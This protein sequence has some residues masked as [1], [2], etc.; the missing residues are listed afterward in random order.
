M[1]QY[2]TVKHLLSVNSHTYINTYIHTYIHTPKFIHTQTNT[3]MYIHTSNIFEEGS[4]NLT[5]TLA[6]SQTYISIS[7]I[8][9]VKWLI[10]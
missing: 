2:G 6:F 1:Y 5:E 4:S 10:R 7:H 3:Y 9:D 8:P